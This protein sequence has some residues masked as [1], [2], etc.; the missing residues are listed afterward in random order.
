MKRN[1]EECLNII[2]NFQSIIESN[3]FDEM[4]REDTKFNC[5]TLKNVWKQKSQQT[6]Y[7]ILHLDHCKYK[8]KKR[9]PKFIN[10]LLKFS[11]TILNKTW[12]SKTE[13]KVWTNVY[14]NL[15]DSNIS[16]QEILDDCMQ[17]LIKNYQLSA[18]VCL[19]QLTDTY[20][21]H[22]S[23]Q[24]WVDEINELKNEKP[25]IANSEPKIC[26]I[27]FEEKSQFSYCKTCT[28]VDQ[29]CCWDC[30]IYNFHAGITLNIEN[31]TSK[32][33]FCKREYTVRDLKKINFIPN[34]NN[35]LELE[36]KKRKINDS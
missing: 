19:G 13:K 18:L 2:N 14:N 30:M 27:C 15:R 35:E 34:V 31:L 6:M 9:H 10:S 12:K 32:C 36:S 25:F 11:E 8:M 28:C 17:K 1:V 7:A 4:C 20:I 5:D 24:Q 26:K 29:N 3:E 33:P 21:F 23:S 16:L 22:D